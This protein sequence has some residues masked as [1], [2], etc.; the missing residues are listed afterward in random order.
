[1]ALALQQAL[2]LPDAIPA[3]KIK[4]ASRARV[5]VSGA[6]DVCW[7][8]NATNNAVP[9]KKARGGSVSGAVSKGAVQ[10][11][12]AQHTSSVLGRS[13]QHHPIRVKGH[14]LLGVCGR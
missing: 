7:G 11:C 1:V 3:D 6:G 9:A 8:R 5:S 14:S 2:N 10:V 12:C 13:R 4:I